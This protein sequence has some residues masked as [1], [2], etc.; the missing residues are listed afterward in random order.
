MIK[1]LLFINFLTFFLYGLDKLKAKY[2]AWRIKEASLLTLTMAG[3][4]LGAFLAMV[5]F[6]HKKRKRFL[7]L[8]PFSPY[9][10][11]EFCFFIFLVFISF[12]KGFFY[13]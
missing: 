4:S 6:N 2:H 3:G 5:L 7:F 12:S 8:L 1:F 10:F 9:L 13:C 11:M